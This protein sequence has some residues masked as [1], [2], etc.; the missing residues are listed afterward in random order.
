M[1]REKHPQWRQAALTTVSWL[2][3]LTLLLVLYAWSW[4][5]VL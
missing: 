5:L 2:M 1:S 3:A 4:K